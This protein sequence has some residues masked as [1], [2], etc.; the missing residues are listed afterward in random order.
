LEIG[1]IFKNKDKKEGNSITDLILA[2]VELLKRDINRLV[3]KV[4]KVLKLV[5]L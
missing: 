3:V 4:Q 2:V 5:K 1:D